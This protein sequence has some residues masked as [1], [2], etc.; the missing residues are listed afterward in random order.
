MLGHITPGS[1][2]DCGAS[3]FVRVRSEKAGY[4]ATISIGKWRNF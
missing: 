3:Q 2:A 1:V 4:R